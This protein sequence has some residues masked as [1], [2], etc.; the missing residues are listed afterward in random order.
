[1]D[2]YT[3][4]AAAQ[5][6]AQNQSVALNS[7]QQIIQY[8]SGQYTT[9]TYTIDSAGNTNGIQLATS[10]GRLVNV[11]VVGEGSGQVK[12]YNTASLTALTDEALLYVLKANAPLGVTTIGLQFNNGLAM[13][14]GEGVAVNATYSVGI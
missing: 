6:A 7:I 13:S 3:N 5:T 11:C 14:V 2:A 8:V 12:F 4:S 10:S 1:M 9:K